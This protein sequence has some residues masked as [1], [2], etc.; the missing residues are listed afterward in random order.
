MDKKH[1]TSNKWIDDGPFYWYMYQWSICTDS[2][3]KNPSY[4]FIF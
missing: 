3:L 1:A 2:F 4:C